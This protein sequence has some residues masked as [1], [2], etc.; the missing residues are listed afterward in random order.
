MSNRR[1]FITLLG[2]A[3][4]AWPLA[5]RAQQPQKVAR[6]GFGLAP[7]SAWSDRLGALRAGLRDLGYVEGKN[8]LIEFRWADR[9][10]Q[11][12]QLAAELV[13]MNVDIIFAPSSTMVEPARQRPRP[14]R[15]CFPITQTP[16]AP[17]MWGQPIQ[18]TQAPRRRGQAAS[19]AL[20]CQAPALKCQA[21]ALNRCLGT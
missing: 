8:I 16:S 14:S 11:L 20:Q 10:D 5:T 4:A 18:L 13:A 12:P 21:P 15:S 9:I 17:G 7:A 19:A 3:A 2:G 1:E 6:I